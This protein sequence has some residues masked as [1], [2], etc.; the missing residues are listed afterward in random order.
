MKNCANTNCSKEFEPRKGGRPQK[1]CSND[2]KR[3]ADKGRFTYEYSRE[4]QL[5]NEYGITLETYNKMNC[6]QGGVCKVCGR[7]E[8]RK[9]CLS[10]DHDHATGAVRSLLCDACNTAIGLLRDDP[11][12]L[13]AA[14]AYLEHHSAA[15]DPMEDANGTKV[16]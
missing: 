16:G 5:R 3:L 6:E 11:T 14:A 7:P 1:Y 2:C 9:Q 10:V 13:R 4:R 15:N 8:T 12:L